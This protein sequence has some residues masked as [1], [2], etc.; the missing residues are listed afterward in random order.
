MPHVLLRQSE[1]ATT[2]GR[3]LPDY[4]YLMANC[5]MH[6]IR[7]ITAT[8]NVG[9]V[10]LNFGGQMKRKSRCT[11]QFQYDQILSENFASKALS[12]SERS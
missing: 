10:Q 3:V 6:H 11:G 5:V 8:P 12:V 4:R 2:I 7:I 1:D 9:Q